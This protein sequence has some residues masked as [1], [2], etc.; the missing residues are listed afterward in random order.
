MRGVTMLGNHDA[1][2]GWDGKRAYLAQDVSAGTPPPRAGLGMAAAVQRLPDGSVRAFRDR[3]GLGKLFWVRGDD[4]ELTWAARPIELVRAGHGFDAVMALP[5]G[6]TL[7]IDAHG[8]IVRESQ[9]PLPKRSQALLQAATPDVGAWIRREMD[10]YLAAIAAAYP[11]RRAYVCLSGGLDSSTIAV[12]VRNHFKDVVAVS[13]DIAGP[14]RP[15][16]EDRLAAR[17]LAGDLGLKLIE[18]TVTTEALLGWLDRVLVDGIDWRDFNV[19]AALVN[20]A[21]AETIAR[22]H[23]RQ[24]PRP[25][26]ITGDLSNE[27]LVDYKPEDYRGRAYYTLPRIDS[28]RLRDILIQGLETTHREAGIFQAWDMPLVQP[29]AVAVEAYMSLSPEFLRDEC[30]KDLLVRHIVGPEL[31]DYIYARPKVRAQLGGTDSGGGVLGACVDRG[32]DAAFLRRRFCALHGVA[33]EDS[34]ERFIRGGRYRAA[35]PL[36]LEAAA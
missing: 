20:A 3:L 15:E 12:L 14:A 36:N 21:L 5:R 29:F 8:Q 13:F 22:H 7:E 31:P 32:I 17:R 2:F 10:N 27:F 9:S 28:A 25:L 23:G 30:R 18:S 19:H 35:I 4:G 16:S 1:I 6:C 33:G 24:E 26:V 34:L 11:H